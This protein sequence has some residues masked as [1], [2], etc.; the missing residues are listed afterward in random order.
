[1]CVEL[2]LGDPLCPVSLFVCTFPA[3]PV[4]FEFL[5]I[6]FLELIIVPAEQTGVRSVKREEMCWCARRGNGN[7]GD[8]DVG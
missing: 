3:L 8:V 2:V 5:A 7:I 4:L 6:F 1:M